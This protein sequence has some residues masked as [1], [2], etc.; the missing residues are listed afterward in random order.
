MSALAL[1]LGMD[2]GT[3]RALGAMHKQ[4]HRALKVA[5]ALGCWCRATNGI[6]QGCPVSVILLN[7][8]TTIW[9]WEVDSLRRQGCA[10]TGAL[11]PPS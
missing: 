7:V 6:L 2:P 9:K 5:E 11:P 3:C 4:L 8:L 10:R 1:E